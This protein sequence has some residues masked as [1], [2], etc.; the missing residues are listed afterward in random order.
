MIVTF[1]LFTASSSKAKFVINLN[2]GLYAWSYHSSR[3][4]VYRPRSGSGSRS[5][6]YAVSGSGFLNK[7]K[8]FYSNLLGLLHSTKYIQAPGEASFPTK[9][10]QTWKFFSFSFFWG[11]ILASLDPDPDLLANFNPDPKHWWALFSRIALCLSCSGTHLEYLWG[12]PADH[13]S[14]IFVSS[15]WSHLSE[16]SSRI[17]VSSFWCRANHVAVDKISVSI[18]SSPE[19]RQVKE[20]VSLR[21]G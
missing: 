3:S 16:H 9:T 5:R 20:T 7:E 17:F 15:C 4:V 14:R 8:M 6:H 10:L 19:T 18:C 11:T 21:R 1:F 12:L 13:S 2:K